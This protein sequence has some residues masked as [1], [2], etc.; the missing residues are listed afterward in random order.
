MATYEKNKKNIYKWR[1]KNIEHNR[2]VNKLAKRRYDIWKKIQKTF[3]AILL[4]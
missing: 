4:I 1:E 3:L 2:E